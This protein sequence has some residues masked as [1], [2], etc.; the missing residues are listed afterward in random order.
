MLSSIAPL[1][2]TLFCTKL[3]LMRRWHFKLQDYFHE[4]NVNRGSVWNSH[5]YGPTWLY[6]DS[7]W[8]HISRYVNEN[9]PRKLELRKASM[10]WRPGKNQ[11]QGWAAAVITLISW[12]QTQCDQHL[13]FFAQCLP[14]HGPLYPGEL[15]AKINPSLLRLPHGRCLVAETIEVT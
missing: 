3:G 12:V 9:V 1:W 5:P 2:N 6:L 10:S 11:R 14:W 4:N 7:P 13:L 8:K 15:Q